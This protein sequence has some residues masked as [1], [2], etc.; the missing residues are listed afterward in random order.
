MKTM[1]L[2]KGTS[3]RGKSQSIKRLTQIF[4]FGAIIRPWQGDDYDSFVIGTVKDEAGKKRIVGIEN[5]G[6]PNYHQKEWIQACIDANCDVI[7]A[8][9]RSYGKT[10]T[11]AYQMGHDNGY[12]VVETSTLF[13]EDGPILPNGI[14]LRDVFAEKMTQVIMRCLK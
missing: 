12:S 6:D 4:P 13:H 10:K 2:V 14:D 8:A 11:D 7:V 3:E 1:I 5:Q 9:C